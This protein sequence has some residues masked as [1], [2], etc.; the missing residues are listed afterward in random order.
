MITADIKA[1]STHQLLWRSGLA[2]RARPHGR[3]GV[4]RSLLDLATIFGAPP[5]ISYNLWI[6]NTTVLRQSPT[7]RGVILPGQTTYHG[8]MRPIPLGA[9]GTFTL[10]VPPAHR[11]NH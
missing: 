11:P 4:A 5:M 7:A 3:H 6:G 8:R 2:S 1:I 10:R 9:K